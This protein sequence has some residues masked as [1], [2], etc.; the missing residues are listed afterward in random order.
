MILYGESLDAQILKD[1]LYYIRQADLLIIG[2]T[3]L[4]VYPAAGLVQECPGSIIII[5]LSP[6]AFDHQADLV[7]KN[8]VGTTLEKAVSLAFS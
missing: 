5:N 4:S 3:S 2:G 7:L 8:K 1:S 6:T